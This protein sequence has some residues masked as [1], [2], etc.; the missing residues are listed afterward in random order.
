MS[1][2]RLYAAITTLA[3]FTENPNPTM[4]T[5]GILSLYTFVVLIALQSIC[6]TTQQKAVNIKQGNLKTWMIEHG[7]ILNEKTYK[8]L[9]NEGITTFEI[10][11]KFT[12]DDFDNMCNQIQNIKIG[13]GDR[14]QLKRILESLSPKDKFIDT[15]ELKAI[16][17][18]NTEITKLTKLLKN[19]NTTKTQIH[20]TKIAISQNINVTFNKLVKELRYRQHELLTD[21]DAIIHDKSKI[22]IKHISM[23]NNSISQFDDT[24]RKCER[25]VRKHVD[26]S[27]IEQRKLQILELKNNVIDGNNVMMQEIGEHKVNTSVVFMMEQEEIINELR[28]IGVVYD[29]PVPK[30][31][32]IKEVGKGSGVVQFVWT[33]LIDTD[34]RNY[35]FLRIAWRN[36]TE[37]YV[38]DGKMMMNGDDWDYKEIMIE[39]GEDMECVNVSINVNGVYLFKLKV[40]DKDNVWSSY[41]NAKSIRIHEQ[42][43]KLQMKHYMISV[44]VLLMLGLGVMFNVFQQ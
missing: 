33:M 42:T 32:D 31:I 27:E 43:Q 16:E 21:L 26:L 30:L 11:K 41:S 14:V 37:K 44:L 17:T 12:S 39:S 35:K 28:G 1:N 29:K 7:H 15:K 38:H 24:R 13:Y 10:F 23:I 9:T 3:I 25:M 22:L 36:F 40:M 2:F 5:H 34:W 6:V 19:L 20:T 8:I 18:I 4:T